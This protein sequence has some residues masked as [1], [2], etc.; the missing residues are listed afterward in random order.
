MTDNMIMQSLIDGE[1]V[2]LSRSDELGVTSFKLPMGL[3]MSTGDVL[4]LR[5]IHHGDT[6]ELS[7]SPA[8]PDGAIVAEATIDVGFGPFDSALACRWEEEE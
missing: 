7:F 5:T 6:R 4:H 2:D 3:T 1:W 8:L